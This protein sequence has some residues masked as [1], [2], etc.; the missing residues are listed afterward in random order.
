MYSTLWRGFAFVKARKG[1]VKLLDSSEYKYNI[2]IYCIVFITSCI[3]P[4]S[5]FFR[6]QINDEYHKIHAV[7]WHNKEIIK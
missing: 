5:I 2:N 3:E 6:R 4:D 7:D 1:N